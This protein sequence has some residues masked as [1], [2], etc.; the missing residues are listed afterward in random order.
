MAASLALVATRILAMPKS[1]F[2]WDDYI[3]G[4]SL[5][6]YA[7]QADVPQAPFFPLFV[8]AARVVRLFV[9]RDVTALSAVSVVASAA[10]L[11]LVWA[12]VRELFGEADASSGLAARAVAVYAFLP[13]VWFYA[14]TPITDT[15]GA[16]ACILVFWLAVRAMRREESRFPAPG[17]AVA[18]GVFGAALGI[19]PQSLVPALLPLAIAW[20]RASGRARLAALGIAAA[21]AALFAV[22]PVAIAAGGL[23]PLAG[24]LRQR[25]AYTGASTSLF[26]GVDWGYVARRWLRDPW[27]S[28]WLAI[29][30]A[31]LMVAGAVRLARL[32][33]P[34]FRPLRLL[35]ASFAPY[36]VLCVV[37][38][39]PTFGSRYL[40][41]L[42]P[43]AAILVASASEGLERSLSSRLRFPL[44]PLFTAAFV[45]ACVVL[46]APAILVVHGRLAPAEEAAARLR[47]RV[48]AAPFA[49]LYSEEMYAPTEL[50][51]PNVPK[52]AVEKTSPDS[53]RAAT[54]LPVWRFGVGSTTDSGE[55]ACWPALPALERL[56][57]GRY[58]VVPFG[59]WSRDS[60]EAGGRWTGPGE[61]RRP[62]GGCTE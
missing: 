15:A 40:L 35:L 18:F 59:P 51:F 2:E 60:P 25:L 26:S 44:V 52:L 55:V 16:A 17:L 39:D 6:L 32:D 23:A 50:L 34:G 21:G 4:L 53:V 3:F 22:V 33:R 5:H 13:A 7:P 10:A 49:L 27:V 37:F 20:L 29:A 45:A 8:Y 47:A 57:P 43:V 12:T 36:G 61:T 24:P 1:L 46:V 62:P 38:L 58:L 14:G 19:R 9:P 42:M 11:P 54:P 30:A 31:A 41:P 56:T 48:G 28:K